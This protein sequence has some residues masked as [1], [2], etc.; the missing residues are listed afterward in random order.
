VPPQILKGYARLVEVDSGINWAAGQSAISVGHVLEIGSSGTR[1][2]SY[3][4]VFPLKEIEFERMTFLGPNDT[5]S[6]LTSLYGDWREP[7]EYPQHIMRAWTSSDPP[8][9]D[10]TL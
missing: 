10:K 1:N 5:D 7:V 6:Y 2:L 9:A 8:P 3:S 4:T